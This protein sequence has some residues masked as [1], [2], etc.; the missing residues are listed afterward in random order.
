MNFSKISFGISRDFPG[1]PDPDPD[2]EN[3][4]GSGFRESLLTPFHVHLHFVRDV[5]IFSSYSV[6]LFICKCVNMA[7]RE[8][9]I[10]ACHD[11]PL[12]LVA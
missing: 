6:Y 3:H 12:F 4:S 5:K 7:T 11:S 1:N 2:P 9:K 10:P 8:K